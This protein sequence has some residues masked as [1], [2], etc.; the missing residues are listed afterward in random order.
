M[1][2]PE[3]PLLPALRVPRSRGRRLIVTATAALCVTAAMGSVTAAPAQA[4]PAAATP[5][6]A[7]WNPLQ[8]K[9]FTS[10][11]VAAKGLTSTP[12]YT[13]STAGDLRSNLAI[14]AGS[15]MAVVAA[16]VTG[17]G[18]AHSS[19]IGGVGSS[20][21]KAL[22][23]VVVR[24]S[25]V[26]GG[27]NAAVGGSVD[28]TNSYLTSDQDGV[29]PLG[30]N[31]ASLP[32]VISYD[33]IQRN[34]VSTAGS[35][36]FHNDGVQMWKGSNVV[37]SRNWISGWAT[38]AIMLKTDELNSDGTPLNHVTITGN[39]LATTGYFTLYIISGGQGLPQYVSVTNNV[40]GPNRSNN[41]SGNIAP[42]SGQKFVKTAAQRTRAVKAGVAGAASWV[43]WSGN[44]D[45][46]TGAEVA[47]P[48]GW[49]S[50]P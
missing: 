41:S 40:F 16:N 25:S 5:A 45:A 2:T 26:S 14:D 43:V 42:A 30:Q 44:T 6:T 21:A 19:I 35:N 12:A 39:Y 49:L 18:V 8:Y 47:P 20:S 17:A 4:A 23:R 27:P 37:I 3:H 33:R 32:S 50:Y 9:Y 13:T 36:G 10:T 46:R 22:S 28:V 48:G 7:A 11:S 15:G 34:G 31:P 24:G 1:V 29:H 38:S